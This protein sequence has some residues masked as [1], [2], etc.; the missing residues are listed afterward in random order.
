MGEGT[1]DWD[2]G[3]W[4]WYKK[5]LGANLSG[6]LNLTQPGFDGE[7][8]NA[9]D[10][11]WGTY[12][13]D[14]I[15][16]EFENEIPANDDS[17][18]QANALDWNFLKRYRDGYHLWAPEHLPSPDDEEPGH[19]GWVKW[20]KD[21]PPEL[22]A[23]YC[24]YSQDELDAEAVELI[25]VDP[26]LDERGAVPAPT[27][28]GV[29]HGIDDEDENGDFDGIPVYVFTQDD[30][31]GRWRVLFTAADA[32][33][34][35]SPQ[36]RT[37]DAVRMLVANK[38]PNSFSM[39]Y[40]QGT[41]LEQPWCGC[42][43]NMYWSRVQRNTNLFPGPPQEEEE[44]AMKV[45]AYAESVL[46]EGIANKDKCRAVCNGGFFDLGTKGVISGVGTGTRWRDFGAPSQRSA[47]GMRK[48]TGAHYTKLMERAAGGDTWV[49]PDVI[50]GWA[51]GLGWVG[52]L[53][54]EMPADWPDGATGR[55]RTFLVFSNSQQR[56]FFEIVVGGEGWTW[57]ETES[58]ITQ[59][60]PQFVRKYDSELSEVN[61]PMMLDG[62]GSSQFIWRH[63]SKEGNAVVRGWYD[64][65]RTVPTLV[66]S[67]YE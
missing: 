22:R 42:W 61:S 49:V 16:L 34:H 11:E 39:R 24:L 26:G 2:T 40:I 64:T 31:P 46:P 44:M 13:Y 62:G 5:D 21:G 7:C 3:G 41:Y 56:H 65:T 6:D 66:Q 4:S 32:A 18:T 12:T 9:D 57:S 23:Y 63:I 47:L 27:V 58:F 45:E 29:G 59:E 51:Y 53:L 43:A 10:H 30:L 50:K 55:P 1:W 60:L 8:L 19:D 25:A 28:R 54:A 15:V 36:W 14:L 35:R 37:H 67:F 52:E 38:D 33:G 48:E 20:P 17:W